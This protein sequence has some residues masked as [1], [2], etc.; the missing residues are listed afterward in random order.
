MVVDENNTCLVYDLATKALL[1][2]E[3]NANSAA[4]N[5]QNE[6]M[7][8]FSGNGNLHIKAANFELHQQKLPG[9]VVGFSGSHIY[10]LHVHS[11]TT[12]EVPQS[13]SMHQYLKKGEFEGAYR[14]A[15]LGVTE[16]DWRILATEA[17]EGLN[18]D[19]GGGFGGK[20]PRGQ[21]GAGLH[22]LC[23]QQKLCG[24]STTPLIL[25]FQSRH[26]CTL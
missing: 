17:L 21:R 7:L 6:D 12:V 15:C 10:C 14:V 2:Q 9:F 22:R 16:A 3:P 26:H 23:R 20:E 1:Y 24:I 18:F 13:H 25:H 8:A 19:V 4:W 11:M 5:S